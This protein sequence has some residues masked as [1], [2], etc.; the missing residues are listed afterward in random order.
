MSGNLFDKP[1][2]SREERRREEQEH[3]LSGIV[4][5]LN[6]YGLNQPSGIPLDR[7]TLRREMFR[8]VKSLPSS[9]PV[10]HRNES[11]SVINARV[12]EQRKPGEDLARFF[13]SQLDSS[14]LIASLREIRGSLGEQGEGF[15]E[16]GIDVVSC[17]KHVLFDL[18]RTRAYMYG[19]AKSVSKIVENPPQNTGK[20]YYVCDA[21]SGAFPVLAIAAALTD[22]RVHVEC[23]E[24]NPFAAV[25][26]KELVRKLGLS[27]QISVI[28]I[29]ARNHRGEDYDLIIS[30]TFDAGCLAEDGASI[31]QHLNV[32]SPHALHI[33]KS[34]SVTAE[35]RGVSEVV[36]GDGTPDQMFVQ[37]PAQE[38]P[39]LAR[40]NHTK[41]IVLHMGKPAT[42]FYFEIPLTNEELRGVKDFNTVALLRTDIV[43]CDG[44]VLKSQQ[45]LQTK[46]VT[47]LPRLTRD[48]NVGPNPFKNEYTLVVSYGAGAQA[49]DVYIHTL[50]GEIVAK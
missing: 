34:L 27:D 42:Q 10:F 18:P 11:S 23:L 41:A 8:L 15:K 13:V 14:T 9:L 2:P 7:G 47:V 22:K 28:N 29:D 20:T 16:Q 21:G 4:R 36:V 35:L 50:Q 48:S 25:I 3:A 5:E 26:A 33:P 44:V 45:S 6:V 24:I 40:K 1:L 38:Q 12:D 30:E 37:T 43:I 17:L 32:K 49:P 46:D 19:V 31:F 39:I